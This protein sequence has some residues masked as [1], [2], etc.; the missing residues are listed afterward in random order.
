MS[1]A[2]NVAFMR[3][4]SPC[5]LECQA[6]LVPLVAPSMIDMDTAW[7][8]P[9]IAHE[10]LYYSVWVV[11]SDNDAIRSARDLGS[12]EVEGLRLAV[13]DIHSLSGYQCV[14]VWLAEQAQQGR[15]S[16]PFSEVLV[17]GGHLKSIA[18]I[19]SGEADVAA[20]DVYVLLSYLR[21]TH[22]E[23]DGFKVLADEVLGP[24]HA[25]VITVSK[26]FLNACGVGVHQ[27]QQMFID[28][29]DQNKEVAARRRS[30]MLIG[31]FRRC[32]A[33]KL[34]ALQDLL[35][36]VVVYTDSLELSHQIQSKL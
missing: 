31:G 2:R 32:D 35:G 4:C 24:Y 14:K 21:E 23:M 25:P 30:E 11:S 19:Q 16:S 34:K 1:D 18:A 36:R 17:S 28:A 3:V 13:N 5:Y 22:N 29:F 7:G 20:I 26:R 12:A 6:D 27:L 8:G 33:K 9:S 10:P 15:A